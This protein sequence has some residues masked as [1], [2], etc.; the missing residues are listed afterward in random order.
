[1]EQLAYE[2]ALEYERESCEQSARELV[3]K[4]NAEMMEVNFESLF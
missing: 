2:G 3:A 4:L 1:M